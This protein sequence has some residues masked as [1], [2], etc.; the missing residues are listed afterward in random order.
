MI[1]YVIGIFAPEFSNIKDWHKKV[2]NNGAISSPPNA[3]SAINSGEIMGFDF[4]S[5]D[6]N[7][8]YSSK[9]CNVYALIILAEMA[10]TSVKILGNK[11]IN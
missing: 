4:F 10:V 8:M 11:P 3:N 5:M 7:R 1:L 6:V 2:S 9:L